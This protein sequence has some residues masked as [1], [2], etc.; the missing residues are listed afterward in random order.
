ML[1]AYV[2]FVDYRYLMDFL[3]EMITTV[4]ER[5]HGAGELEFAGELISMARPWRRLTMLE[6][7]SEYA[8][9]DADIETAPSKLK[10]I[11][12]DNQLEVP[13]GAGS[14]WMIA[15]LYEKLVEPRLI[16]PTFV[17]DYPEEISPL[18]RGKPG[19]PGLTERFEILIAGQEVANAFSELADPVEQR[20]RFEQ[21]AAKAA[22][23]DEEAHRV[24]EDFL[25]ALEYG[26][27]PAGGIGV[28][29]DRLTMLATGCQNIRDVIIFPH[30]RPR[31]GRSST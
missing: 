10:S 5:V 20:R 23:G 7:L 19:S 30:L 18:A 2:A 22:A 12:E 13:P 14:G 29:V 1:E 25:S 4:V 9:I 24:D 15:E 17:V 3:E 21:Q 8:G 16:Q 6:A 28:G 26:M 27:P 11:T 31:E